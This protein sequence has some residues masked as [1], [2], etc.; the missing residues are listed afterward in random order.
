[1]CITFI[2]LPH[3]DDNSNIKVVV[4]M[5]RDEFYARPTSSARW[6]GDM[7]GSWDMEPGREGGTWLACQRDGRIGMLT[8]I[9]TGGIMDKEAKGRGFLVVDYLKTEHRAETYLDLVSSSD[10]T[11]NPFNLILLEP[12][13]DKYSLWLYSRGK[14]GHT[15]SC[16]PEKFM[17]GTF[18]ISNHP[19]N[20]KYKK[21]AKGED[22]LREIVKKCSCTEDL[23]AQLE[24]LLKDSELNW[25]D[26]QIEAQKQVKGEAG[27]VAKFS[28]HLSSININIEEA[29]YGTRTHTLIVVDN[30]NNFHFKE[31]TRDQGDWK[32]TGERF[33]VN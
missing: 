19:V 22:L 9:F 1:M 12:E 17:H 26:P 8:N 6:N 28:K 29:G 21:S 25:P 13:D 5:N 20:K 16:P 27:P 30:E 3:P 14:E 18:G 7:L 2:H 33:D 31:I 32:T 23:L 10:I 15:E 24:G 11:Y 4:A